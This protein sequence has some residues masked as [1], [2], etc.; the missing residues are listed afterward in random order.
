MALQLHSRVLCPWATLC[1][2]TAIGCGGSNEP[3][4]MT[5]NNTA[6]AGSTTKPDTAPAAG[7]TSTPPA[8][9][10][11]TTSSGSSNGG[12]GGTSASSTS[13]G[14]TSAPSSSG[15]AGSTS[16]GNGMFSPSCDEVPKTAA[17]AAPAKGGACTASDPQLCYKN[18]GP[19]SV[20]FKSETCTN[21]AYAEQSGC[22]FP[23]A[24][25][26]CYKIPAMVDATCPTTTP[27][28]TMPCDVAPCTPCNVNGNYQES[29]GGSKAGYCVCPM[30]GASG[31]RK[32][33]CAST[34]AWPCPSGK[35]C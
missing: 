27:Q 21:G 16:S 2:L 4:V 19:L 17:G 15:E 8:A 25:Y 3:S 29:G 1:L 12:K 26:A 13:A 31:M 20:G 22:S 35:G 10:G 33:S 18:C 6:T 5:G 32:W 11:G 23:D 9:N 14:G 24:D 28:A 34:T 30:P 7:K